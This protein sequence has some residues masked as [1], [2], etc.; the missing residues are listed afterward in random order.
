MR[1]N[2]ASDTDLRDPMLRDIYREMVRQETRPER[3]FRSVDFGFEHSP[4]GKGYKAMKWL[5]GANQLMDAIFAKRTGQ[6]SAETE[7]RPFDPDSP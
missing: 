5:L 2:G 1:L 4:I 6:S 3:V 7:L